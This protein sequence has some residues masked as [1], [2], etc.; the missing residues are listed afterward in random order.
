MCS[1]PTGDWWRQPAWVARELGVPSYFEFYRSPDAPDGVG[2][3]HGRPNR[4]ALRTFSKAY[5]LAGLRVEAELFERVERIV[6]ERGRTR[7]ALLGLGWDVL[8]SETNFLW[9]P[10]G[11]MPRRRWL[12]SG[13][14]AVCW[15]EPSRAAACG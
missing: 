3:H 4:L 15:S 12:R 14:G 2:L 7:E 10:T 1:F 8:P 13:N 6:A 5:G 11:A 9:L